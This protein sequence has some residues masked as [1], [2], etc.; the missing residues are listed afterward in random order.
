VKH[1][2]ERTK[3]KSIIST[4]SGG[5]SDSQDSAP[6][7]KKSKVIRPPPASHAPDSDAGSDKRSPVKKCSVPLPRLTPEKLQEQFAKSTLAVPVPLPKLTARNLEEKF[8]KSFKP[9]SNFDDVL[10]NQLL[11]LKEAKAA[12]QKRQREKTRARRAAIAEKRLQQLQKTEAQPKAV[13][14]KPAPKKRATSKTP[15]SVET[16]SSTNSDSSSASPLSD[17]SGYYRKRKQAIPWGNIPEKGYPWYEQVQFRR[18]DHWILTPAG[19]SVWIP[20]LIIDSLKKIRK[21]ND[22]FRFIMQSTLGSMN[23][24]YGRVT[25]SR[26]F[27]Q[28]LHINRN[29]WA[30]LAKIVNFLKSQN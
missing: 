17:Q 8:D 12:D 11:S 3:G 28:I 9:S 29:H 18:R 23:L 14:Q 22:E 15:K 27:I 2:P 19:K 30:G 6:E 10:D 13:R 26:P 5:D 1:F 21:S 4:D 24:R 16:L 25:C 7:K 20:A